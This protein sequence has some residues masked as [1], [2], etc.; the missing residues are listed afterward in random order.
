D[1]FRLGGNSIMAIKLV[2]KIYQGTGI[3]PKVID[4]FNEKTINRL[5]LVI[6]HYEP[7][8]KAVIPLN[9]IMGK[10]KV[11]MIHPGGAGCEVY[12]ALAEQ[13]KPYCQC[14]GVDSYNLYNDEKISNLN[15]LAVYYLNHIKAIQKASQQEEYI[16]IGWCL[17]GQIALEIASILESSGHKN[18]TVLML[19]TILRAEDA[20]L[21]EL[22]SIPT[23]E[24][25]SEEFKAPTDSELFLASKKF[26]L[27]E[28]CIVGQG[29]STPLRFTRLV[30]L[31]AMTKG[32]KE[33]QLLFNHIHRLNY[34]NV[35]KI[36]ENPDL[37]LVYPVEA[38]H[39]EIIKEEEFIIDI[40]KSIIQ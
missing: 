18:I 22:S 15:G 5:S 13:L 23:D 33:N 9:H 6:N 39:Q 21:M 19:D 8:Y 14:Y 4:V 2:N 20:K 11:F 3:Q 12:K 24:E 16:L 34:N 31:K 1:F 26:A 35:D 36:I 7:E 28:H 27:A 30:L 29:I 38:S 17:G 10:P 37:L 25:I 40:I 32:E